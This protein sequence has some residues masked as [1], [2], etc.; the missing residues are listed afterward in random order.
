MDTGS[1]LMR[2][3]EAMGRHFGPLHW[4][5]AETPFEVMVG[6]ILTQNTS[7]ANVEKAIGNLAAAGALD[8]RAIDAM[9]ADVLAGL[10]RPAGYYNVKAGRLKAFVRWF[11]DRFDGD[12]EAMAAAD[13]A[14]LRRE[15]L[16]VRGVGRETADSILLYACQVPV[17]VVDKYTWRICA[18]HLLIDPEDD[19]DAIQQFFID[20]LPAEAPLYN[21]V[22]AQLVNVG[23]TF[24]R[25]T[26]RCAGCPL[27]AFEHRADEV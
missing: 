7:W 24:C 19:Y 3:H 25:P 1:L 8:P 15:V 4:W 2:M 17:F 12:A 9:A 6:A 27:A 5:P 13:P 11:L 10:I 26:A 16:T 18:R 21:E 22:H 23:K 14:A 20:H